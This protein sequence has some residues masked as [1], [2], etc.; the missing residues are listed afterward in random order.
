MVRP[1][2]I[3]SPDHDL[4]YKSNMQIL[5]EQDPANQPV[6][7]SDE[8]WAQNRDCPFSDQQ[9]P[10]LHRAWGWSR[11]RIDDVRRAI[12]SS[13]VPDTLA[14]VAIS[15]SLSR[16]EAHEQSDLDLLIVL[17]DRQ[18]EMDSAEAAHLHSE[19]WRRI[20]SAPGGE[21]T[22]RPKPGGIFASAVSWNHLTDTS[23]RGTVDE[24]LI[25]Y[26]QRMQLLLDSQPIQ[27]TSRFTELQRDLFRWYA[28]TRVGSQ[29]GE[30]S[31]FHW[32]WQDV[33]RYWRSLRSRACWLY[34]DR[35]AQ[36]L[37]INLKLRSSR[38]VLVAAFLTAVV[39]ASLPQRPFDRIVADLC[40]A[41]K[42]TPLERII[43]TM[44][45]EVA[46]FQS[47]YEHL[48]S[49]CRIAGTSDI[50]ISE[51][52]RLAMREI[53]RLLATALPGPNTDWVF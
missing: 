39:A 36:S 11:R 35:P 50:A 52:D 42:R 20:E 13:A 8:E 24:D 18:T 51:Q 23:R 47:H 41:L 28:E 44:D 43:T 16:M 33:Q 12:K 1:D 34:A 32:L 3:A 22:R 49:R 6:R 45:Q 27:N 21:S 17:N 40:K 5:D 4:L 37:E 53:A 25:T 38:I 9:W 31:P 26:G 10:L 19:I 14:C 46:N 48:W 29:F 2:L 7:P 30:S 15:G